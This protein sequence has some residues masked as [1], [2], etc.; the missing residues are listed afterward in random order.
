MID[1]SSYKTYLSAHGAN[2][3]Q[4]RRNQTDFTINAT[5]DHDPTYRQIYILTPEGWKWE[6]AKYQFHN[7]QSIA[8]DKVD[9]YLQF[10]PKVH[11]PIGCYVMIPD[12]TDPVLHFTEDELENPFLCWEKYHK[13]F[14]FIAERDNQNAYVR[15]NVLPC[16]HV[17]KWI[18]DGQKYSVLGSIRAANSYTSCVYTRLAIRKRNS[19]FLRICWDTLRAITLKQRDE[20]RSN[21]KQKKVMDWAISRENSNRIALNDYWLKYH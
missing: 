6:E 8:K 18:Y 3:A 13:Y 2:I 7:A 14:W 17:F 12:D 11:Y 10:R 4:V 20:K 19:V 21:G 1:A 15:Y 16:N 5:F 9:N